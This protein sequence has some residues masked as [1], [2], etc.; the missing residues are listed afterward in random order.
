[1]EERTCTPESE[2]EAKPLH[3]GVRNGCTGSL[4]GMDWG[5]IAPIPGCFCEII[6]IKAGIAYFDAAPIGELP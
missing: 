1:M 2:K 4:L 3:A 5:N 6:R